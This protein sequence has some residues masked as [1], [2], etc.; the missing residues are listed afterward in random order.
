[1]CRGGGHAV[2]RSQRRSRE[3]SSS[4]AIGLKSW[5][6]PLG[7]FFETFF[8]A[9]DYYGDPLT[10][11]PW[12]LHADQVAKKVSREPPCMRLPPLAGN[13]CVVA[14]AGWQR[15]STPALLRF[16]SAILFV[17]MLPHWKRRRPPTR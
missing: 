3:G 10:C 5:S 2:R 15:L 17:S 9:G 1:M 13:L 16:S 14:A 6:L 11:L 12:L 7:Q 8:Y 4:P